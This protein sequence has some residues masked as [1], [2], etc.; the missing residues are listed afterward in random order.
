MPSSYVSLPAALASLRT[1]EE[2]AAFLTD[3]TTPAEQ[4]ALKERWRIANM[5]FEGGKSYRDI[6]A[7]TGASTTTVARVARFLNSENNRGYQVLL[8]R[9]A[10]MRRKK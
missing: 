7:E 1:E 3:L 10:R 9:M 4:D 2:A 8:E 5:L 6:A